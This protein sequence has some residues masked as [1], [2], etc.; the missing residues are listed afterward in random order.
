MTAKENRAMQ[1]ELHRMSRANADA[2]AK[3]A[4]LEAECARLRMIIKKETEKHS[5]KYYAILKQCNALQTAQREMTEAM[6]RE[7][8]AIQRER[9][10]MARKLEKM[11][12]EIQQEIQQKIRQETLSQR[13]SNLVEMITMK[14]NL[15][16]RCSEFIANK[17]K[18]LD[19]EKKKLE[20]MV[21]SEKKARA[22]REE[23]NVICFLARMEEFEK[24]KNDIAAQLEE[25]RQQF[26]KE[27]KQRIQ[28][29]KHQQ[30]QLEEQLKAQ[31]TDRMEELEKQKAHDAMQLEKI[32]KQF[33]EECN[34]RQKQLE[35]EQNQLEIQIRKYLVTNNEL[36]EKIL[37]TEL[38]RNGLMAEAEKRFEDYVKKHTA[39]LVKTISFSQMSHSIAAN[40]A[41]MHMIYHHL[42]FNQKRV[43]IYSHYSENDEVE[44]YNYLTLEKMEDRFDYVIVLTNCPNKW[45]FSNANYN[46][47]HVLWYNFK[48]D[49]RNYAVFIMQTGKQI[50]RAS[51][52]CL[53]NDSFVVVDVLAFDRCMQRLFDPSSTHDFAGITSSH[54]GVYHLQSYFMCFNS[55]T[56]D[57]VVEYFYTHGLPINHHASISVYE[58]GITKHLIK[59]G[60]TSFAMVSNQEMPIPLNTTH[61]KW[62]QVLQTTGIVKRQHFLKQY[63]QRFAMTD[64][65]IALV[66]NKFSENKHFIHFLNYH[67]IKLD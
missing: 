36:T 39:T 51:Q 43:L 20:D 2:V 12:E 55:R 53:M 67:G 58:L 52:L 17:T 13:Q 48:S 65:N 15:D 40:Y 62:S 11:H 64:L 44:S 31:Y 27:C 38:E 60:F 45:K 28:T 63:P 34:Q 18:E 3:N 66:A 24:Q 22:Q 19:A 35:T 10:G 49:F 6:Q 47:F 37:Q 54:E 25:A 61:C 7:R 1:L 56:L 32:K 57:A 59:Q 41:H 8:D 50:K 33:E 9:Q 14:H 42:D 5:E 21:L 16:A 46:K 30:I 4:A 23:E 26:E 29:D